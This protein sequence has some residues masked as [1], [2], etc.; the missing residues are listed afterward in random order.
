M[1]REFSA[2]AVVYRR[3]KEG[4]YFLLLHYNLGH[5]DF[6][7]GHIK[8]GEEEQDTVRREIAEETAIKRL[9]FIDG[10]RLIGKQLC[11]LPRRRF[12]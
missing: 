4:L 6:P 1:T 2:G 12:S 7:K 10:F 5:W 11:P 3:T 8:K 9:R